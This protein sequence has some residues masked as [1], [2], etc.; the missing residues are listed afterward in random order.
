MA[1]NPKGLKIT[2][3]EVSQEFDLETLTGVDLSENKRLFRAIQQDIIDYTIKRAASGKG[4][5]GTTLKTPYSESYANSAA[6]KAAGKSKGNVNM[7]LYG[8]M[9]GSMDVLG[10]DG[11]SFT[12]GFTDQEQNVKAFAHMSGYE[13]HPTISGPKRKFFGLTGD[14]VKK[15]L[16]GYADDISKLK[17]SEPKEQTRRQESEPAQENDFE[18]FLNRVSKI[19]DIVDFE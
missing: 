11:A 9:L 19:T 1:S 14:E 8:D 4:I 13:G 12:I 18:Q 3:D 6:F 16:S 15:I 17:Q 2:Y 7:R 5:G 10:E